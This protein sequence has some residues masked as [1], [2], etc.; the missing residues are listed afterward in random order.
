MADCIRSRSTRH[1]GC[2]VEPR[3]RSCPRV[4][5]S[6]STSTTSASRTAAPAPAERRRRRRRPRSPGWSRRRPSA[7]SRRSG[8]RGPERGRRRSSWMSRAVPSPPAKRIRSTPRRD[9]LGGGG[10]RVGGARRTPVPARGPAPRCRSRVRRRGRRPSRPARPGPSASRRPRSSRAS[11]RSVRRPRRASRPARR[12]CVDDAVG[13]LEPDA[14]AHAGDRVDD[15]PDAA[16]GARPRCGARRPP[17]RPLGATVPTISSS[18]SSE[19]TNGGAK[20]IVS[21]AGSARVI[22]PS[23]RQR[24]VTRA[25]DLRPRVE[26]SAPATGRRRTRARRSARGRGSRPRADGRRTPPASRSCMNAP[27]LAACATS[28]S[29]SIRSRF[30]IATAAASGWRAVRVAVAED[31]A[32]PSLRRRG[33]ARP[34]PRRCRPRAARSRRSFPSRR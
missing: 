14:A 28:P 23:S 30:V 7:S 9:E 29:S 19:I 3:L 32:S 20:E 13:A 17:R 26:R 22:T 6:S 4:R 2:P 12:A 15:Q 31:A 33:R 34:S 21:E 18:S 24:R 25:A 8:F 5:R 11:A 27:R 10:A 1:A 16:H